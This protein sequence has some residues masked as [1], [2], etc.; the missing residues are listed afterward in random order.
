MNDLVLLSMYVDD[1]TQLEDEEK[2]TNKAG[3]KIKTIGDK[4]LDYET[5]AFNV[6]A[7]PLYKFLD[8]EGKPL[9]DVQY[10]YD[11]DA[12][13]FITHLEN[14]KTAFYKK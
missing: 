5:S 14:V 13:K 9:S 2:Y 6:N 8:S 11:P 1:K 3:E 10:G 7:Q 4:N 12:I